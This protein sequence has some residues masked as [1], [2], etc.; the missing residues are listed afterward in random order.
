MHDFEQQRKILQANYN[1]TNKLEYKEFLDISIETLDTIINYLYN[2]YG[3]HAAST[4]VIY[5]STDNVSVF[6]TDGIHKLKSLEFV[7]PIQ[8]YIADH[9]R[10]VG[11][12]IEKKAKDGTTTGMIFVSKL[13][14][15][16]LF[17]IRKYTDFDSLYKKITEPISNQAGVAKYLS[18]LDLQKYFI[19]LIS[20]YTIEILEELTDRMNYDIV[21]LKELQT[22]ER[23]KYIS[24][25]IDITAKEHSGIIKDKILTLLQKMPVEFHDSFS[26]TRSDIET[27]ELI[28]IEN[29]DHEYISDIIVNRGIEYFNQNGK[30]A[31]EGKVDLLIFPYV[32]EHINEAVTQLTDILDA[33]TSDN[34]FVLFYKRVNESYIKEITEKYK[35]KKII[36]VQYIHHIPEIYESCI[37][38]VGLID[39]WKSDTNYIQ[40]IDCKIEFGNIKLNGIFEFD[41]TYDVVNSLYYQKDAEKFQTWVKEITTIIEKLKTKYKK[42]DVNRLVSDYTYIYKKIVTPRFSTIKIG[43]KTLEHL[44][45]VDVIEDTLGSL[46]TIIKNGVLKNYFVEVIRHIR[47]KRNTETDIRYLREKTNKYLE[48]YNIS[49]L[50]LRKYIYGS[51]INIFNE[52]EYKKS[53]ID[54]NPVYLNTETI[55]EMYKC[56]IDILPRFIKTIEIVIPGTVSISKTKKE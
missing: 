38:L 46:S 18:G 14:K 42:V 48:Y 33:H 32:F 44:E 35:D 13:L 10:Y 1:H 47:Q 50:D 25:I 56:A 39:G 2:S 3:Q 26:Y 34:T 51:L 54:K 41:K 22:Y 15:S 8:N 45:I 21:K 53:I 36:G 9:I 49:E 28:S 16:I 55:R 40:N 11:E 24:R 7:S 29:K 31:F 4:L 27:E 20:T 23:K 52:L 43:G 12:C 5:E 17:Y 19:S 30:S 6:T 37:E